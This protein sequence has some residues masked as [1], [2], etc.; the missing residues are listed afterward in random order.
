[1]A[2]EIVMPQMGMVQTEG[3]VVEWLCAEGDRVAAGEVVAQVETDKAVVDVESPCDGTII[4]LAATGEPISIGTTIGL[5][6]EPDEPAPDESAPPAPAMDSPGRPTAD[7]ATPPVDSAGL[8]TADSATLPLRG[9]EPGAGTVAAASGAGANMAER[10]AAPGARRLAAELGVALADVAATGP[11]GRIVEGDVRRFAEAGAAGGEAPAQ[12]TDHQVTGVRATMAQRMQASGREIPHFWLRRQV[13]AA[14]LLA[15]RRPGATR[16]ARPVE[17]WIVD[18]CATALRHHPEANAAWH[19]GAVRRYHRVNIG[20]AVATE[21]GLLVPVIHDADRLGPDERAEAR[22]RLVERARAG[23]LGADELRD[24]TF[25]VTN[26]GALGADA[27]WPLVTPGQ[28]AVLCVGR[29]R[30]VAGVADG[31]VAPVFAVEL[32]LGADHRVLDGAEGAALLD[33]IA[34]ALGSTP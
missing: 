11:G 26:V 2:R 31:Q 28:A 24:A 29:A 19:D 1:V 22:R 17:D 12:W 15:E 4:S 14:P 6:V 20:V 23:R 33:T 3:T 34:G 5:V 10:P 27:G 30:W 18:A 7:S 32:L 13:D 16:L 21:Q 25:T 8:P 9:A